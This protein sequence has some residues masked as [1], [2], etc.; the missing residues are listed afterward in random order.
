[1]SYLIYRNVVLERYFMES[2]KNIIDKTA[3]READL[4]IKENLIRDY[5]KKLEE[6]GIC[7]S[8]NEL[9]SKNIIDAK[10]VFEKEIEQ[11][12]MIAKDRVSKKAIFP[13]VI[14]PC[15]DE[16]F[17]LVNDYFASAPEDPFSIIPCFEEGVVKVNTAAWLYY[18]IM[19]LD[20][21]DNNIVTVDILIQV[22]SQDVYSAGYRFMRQFEFELKDNGKFGFNINTNVNKHFGAILTELQNEMGWTSEQKKFWTENVVN[23]YNDHEEKYENYMRSVVGDKMAIQP[24]ATYYDLDYTGLFLFVIRYVNAKLEEYKVSHA[25]KY[26]SKTSKSLVNDT[27]IIKA[28]EKRRLRTISTGAHEINIISESAPKKPNEKYIKHYSVA[29]WQ[30]RGFVRHLKSGKTTYIKPQTKHRHA[31]MD[32]NVILP[33]VPTTIKIKEVKEKEDGK[34]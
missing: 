1:M 22:Y 8:K 5:Q 2:F 15:T 28:A 26:V 25:K 31:L 4:V 21:E 16:F 6:K 33:E 14:G 27:P 32:K 7:L 30:Q 3:K 10:D 12:A 9:L 18:K 17:D 19:D 23:V 34:H 29:T 24:G 20:I 13:S 11:L